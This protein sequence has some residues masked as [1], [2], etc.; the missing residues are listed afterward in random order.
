M[1]ARVT[2]RRV[3]WPLGWVAAGKAAIDGQL[4]RDAHRLMPGATQHRAACC[5]KGH[6]STQQPSACCVAPG[7]EVG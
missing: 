1:T 6:P 4:D 3:A 5:V 2:R 7:L